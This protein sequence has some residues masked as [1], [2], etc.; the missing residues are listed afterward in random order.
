MENN[1][2]DISRDYLLKS[3]L[4]LSI[5]WAVLYYGSNLVLPLL[6]AA[7]VATI[8]N[9]PTKKLIQWGF[10]N[11]LAISVSVLLLT[12]VI[13][14][15]FWLI[16]AQVGNMADDW[17]TIEEKAMEKYSA[18]NQWISENFEI[19]MESFVNNKLDVVSKLKGLFTAF[20]AS[21]SNL[22]SQSFIILI[23]TILFLMQKKTFIK[24]FMKLVKSE[25]AACI[26][27][28]NS[29]KI[30]NDYLFGKGKIMVFLFIIYYLGFT[31]GQV[32]YALF[33]ALFA[34]LF[35]IIP[36]VGNLIGGGVAIILSYLYSGG[37][38]ALIVIGVMAVAQLVE[39]Y[40]LTPWI[41]GDE[42][43]L[44]PFITIFGVIL[45]SVLWGVVG[46]VIALPVLG[47][48]KVLFEHTKGLE[49]YALLFGKH[50]T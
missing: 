8:L 41:I 31:L 2:I 1:K 47:I 35:S 29:A 6:V 33:L 40:V 45:L 4:L 11:W 30:V 12:V 17:P 3:V 27:L 50:D 19:D 26:I 25:K 13:L 18:L 38:P 43:D 14:F 10:A 39:N 32:P 46:A 49:A 44:N 42:I 21:L 5:I 23:Y 48:L 20:I 28:K 36:Y 15:L 9:E 22:V 24:F 37:T 7:I 34:A 16:S